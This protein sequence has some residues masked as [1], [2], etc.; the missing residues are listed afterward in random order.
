M[1]KVSGSSIR[2]SSLTLKNNLLPTTY[3]GDRRGMFPL[4]EILILPLLT[5]FLCSQEHQGQGQHYRMPFCKATGTSSQPY[6]L[7][8][9]QA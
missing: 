9:L 4:P 8:S 1:L 2:S 5:C 3:P 6:R 7:S